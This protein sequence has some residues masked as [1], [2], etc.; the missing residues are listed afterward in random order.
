MSDKMNM[1]RRTAL[2]TFG[3][4][5]AGA[6]AAPSVI[7]R[8]LAAGETLVVYNFDGLLGKVIKDHWIDPF[9]QTTGVKVEVLTMQGSSPPMAKIKAQVDA[10]RP[11][12]D[13]IPMQMPDYVFGVRNNLFQTIDAKDMPEYANLYPDYITPHGPKLVLWSYGLAYNTDKIK[14]APTAWADLWDPQYKGKAALNEA[15]FDQ[16]LQMANLVA[17]GKP[18]PVDDATFAALTRLRPNLATLWTTGAQA[19]QLL[20]TG[21][22]WIMPVWNGRVYPLKDQGVPIDFV[23]PKEGFFTRADPFCIPRGAKNPDLAKAF[24]NFSC[25]VAPQQALAKGLFYASPNQKVVYPP[26]IAKRVVVSTREELA[27]AVPENFEVIVDN[28]PDW[29]RRWDAWKQS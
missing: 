24:I 13:V 16:A 27:R 1:S 6:L 8:S 11:D 17:K 5:A 28:L 23:S 3:V 18:L 7:T 2:K 14:T 21:E 29:R 10:G 19:E 25:T 12:A 4:A 22:V 15:L 9:S 26:E 20:R